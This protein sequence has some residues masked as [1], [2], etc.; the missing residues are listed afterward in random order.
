MDLSSL[1]TVLTGTAP[2]T[3]VWIDASRA[4]ENGG[5]EVQLRWQ[6]LA[7]R[8]RDLGAPDA[9]I[10]ALAAVAAAPTGRPDPS[11]RLLA[12]RSGSVVLDEVVGVQPPDGIGE[13]SFDQLPDVTP[14][15]TDRHGEVPFVVARIDRTGADVDVFA[16][17]DAPATD[18]AHVK[19]RTKHIHKF[20]GGGW[21]H[22]RFQHNTEE[23]WRKNAE[24]VAAVVDEKARAHGVKLLVLG[25]DQRARTFVVE[26]LP[27]DFY[28]V[29]EVEGNVRAEGASEDQLEAAVE[30]AV[31]A[32]LTGSV[33]DT[34]E[35]LR[36]A[37]EPMHDGTEIGQAAVDVE[38]T[39]A[40]FQ[41][42][43]VSVLLVDPPALR[44]RTLVVG[45]GP[46]DIALPGGPRTWQGEAVTVPADLA[47]VRAAV[48]TD[49]EVQPLPGGEGDVPDGAA[50]LLRWGGE[51]SP[52]ALP[53]P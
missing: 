53:L 1:R 10:E 39:V 40:A 45:P 19:G 37:R 7:D 28:D 32:K 48:L 13:V 43:Q 9:D 4:D 3:T 15:L 2:T 21:A 14:L 11:A 17:V 34:V 29:V 47:L 27:N 51:G 33:A 16:A 18:S 22:L 31:A 41:Q 42:G 52:A 25:G 38:R 8:L 23:A 49:A 46:H 44:A 30:T 5:R 20:G 6:G 26:A 12:A 36:A 50:A 24:E 35:R